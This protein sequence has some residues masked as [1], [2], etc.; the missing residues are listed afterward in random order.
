MNNTLEE[1]KENIIS[2]DPVEEEWMKKPDE[3]LKDEEKVKKQEFQL[4]KKKHEEEV[5]K[6]KKKL[7]QDLKK[8]RDKINEVCTNFDQKLF[9]LFTK[10]LEYQ[11]RI[12][13]QEGYIVKLLSS[14]NAERQYG[15]QLRGD[16][17]RLSI[18]NT[19]IEDYS[20]YL[21]ALENTKSSLETE[22]NR[23]KEAISRLIKFGKVDLSIHFDKFT[24]DLENERK[25]LQECT[26]E[27][28][29]RFRERHPEVE[30]RVVETDIFNEIENDI[31]KKQAVYEPEQYKPAIDEAEHNS[32]KK[33]EAK[34][35]Q[36]FF[37]KFNTAVESRIKNK[38]D[39]ASIKAINEVIKRAQEEESR[40]REDILRIEEDKQRHSL[41]EYAEK[42]NIF[43]EI[44]LL[45]RMVEIPNIHSYHTIE[46]TVLTELYL[47]NRLNEEIC[48]RGKFKVQNLEKAIKDE[49]HVKQ[50]EFQVQQRQLEIE[51]L[52]LESMAITRL[53]VTRKLQAALSEE[54]ENEKEEKNLEDQIKTLKK[55]RDKRIED[56]ELKRRAMK[57]EIEAIR[58]Q[59]DTLTAE[60]AKLQD[61]VLQRKKI[62]HMMESKTGA[63]IEENM[64]SDHKSPDDKNKGKDSKNDNQAYKKAMYD[65]NYLGKLHTTE[66]SLT[67]Q[68]SLHK[69]LSS[70]CKN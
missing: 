36:T 62:L 38:K 44:R 56:M 51:D 19:E 1:K 34:D 21:A 2:N 37:D 61:T 52:I 29:N 46:G 43:I 6:L 3:E 63:P 25:A 64:D 49:S 47:I 16:A 42:N 23:R 20:T 33:T 41:D 18:K 55:T 40:L 15:L 13:E 11:Y 8:L 53:K 60:G 68:R 58:L 57:K 66:G 4:R 26:D 28:I 7:E 24:K 31:I 50:I 30:R 35:N 32:L 9:V 59:N 27:M 10:R 17:E 48:T 39:E 22:L 45:N 14:I 69:N 70:L 65:L 67:R 5:M 12:Y 54:K